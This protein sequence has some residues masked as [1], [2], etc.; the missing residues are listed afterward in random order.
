MLTGGRQV[1]VRNDTKDRMV[2][3]AALMLREHGVTGTSF[4]K[5][6]RSCG[7]PRGS[8]GFHF[9]GGKA[10]LVTEAVAWAGNLVTRA[11]TKAN[12]TGMPAEKTFAALCDNYRQQLLTTDFAA[13]CPVGA[14][15]QEGH[16]DPDLSA[17][18]G[19]VLTDW[20]S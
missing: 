17:A 13:G 18:V 10:Q 6:L 11:L 5:V 4:A 1:G 16:A 12:A 15:A 9:P 2:T 19:A 14:V 20:R 7:G 8:I 3:S